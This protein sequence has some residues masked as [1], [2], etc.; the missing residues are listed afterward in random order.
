MIQAV[1]K[2]AKILE[3]VQRGPD[4]RLRLV[5]IAR[6]LGM[7][8]P[9][10]FNL[11]KTLLSLEYLAQDGPGGDYRLGPKLLELTQGGLG[12]VFLANLARPLCEEAG[13]ELGESVSLVA[14]R[15]GAVKIICRVLCDNEI[16]VSPNTFK[17]L[18]TTVSGR[19]LLAQLPEDQ[20]R[21]V[22]GLQ[23]VPGELWEGAETQAGLQ[24]ALA[25][26]K[27]AG[28]TT[29]LSEKRQLGGVG[30]VIDAPAPH[31]PI[32]LGAAMPLFR[33]NAKREQVHATLK[34]CATRIANQLK[35]ST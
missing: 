2:A 30:F 12:D 34:N 35:P 23:G 22:V 28:G 18:Y 25:D 13:K 6:E 9:T 26:I 15:Q 33:F 20:V 8:K 4:G 17:P 31:H 24:R 14:Y 5:D 27:A 11:I 10:A 16:V 29:F 19:C 1:V 7:E 32:A 21:N 3:T